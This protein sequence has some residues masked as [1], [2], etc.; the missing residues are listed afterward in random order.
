VL[1]CWG[2]DDVKELRYA[3]DASDGP[4]NAEMVRRG[5]KNHVISTQRLATEGNTAAIS[6]PGG[7][8]TIPAIDNMIHYSGAG[9]LQFQIPTRSQANAGF[10]QDNFNKVLG[11]PSLYLGPNSPNGN[12]FY[13]Q[14]K[15]RL[16]DVMLNTTIRELAGSYFGLLSTSG[17]GSDILITD[18][19][20]RFE[21]SFAGREIYILYSQNNFVAG[22]YRITQFIDATHIKLDRSPTPNGAGKSGFGAV[23]GDPDTGRWNGV[24]STPGRGSN[25]VVHSG[26]PYD[27]FTKG[28]VG[29]VFQIRFNGNNFV[30]GNY[31][32]TEFIDATHLRLNQSPTPAGAGTQ[33]WGVTGRIAG[34]W[35]VGL[36]TG[37]A[38]HGFFSYETVMNNGYQLGY[39]QIYGNLGVEGAPV[40]RSV[41]YRAN[42]WQ[43]ITI[44]EEVRGPAR[45]TP[46][47]R[48][49]WWVDGVLA[50]NW[51]THTIFWGDDGHGGQTGPGQFQML[52]YHT[53]KDLTQDHDTGYMWLDDLI[54]STQPIPMTK[55]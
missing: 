10:F 40:Q 41:T 6:Q 9:S 16:N 25:V 38:P 29:K 31:T 44:R 53:N 1:G 37:N 47:S 45:F 14:F 42:Q 28:M 48:V 20:L 15:L 5:L 32:V 19:A 24:L 11:N 8:L 2:F 46:V 54:V 3:W 39:P 26:S 55:Q 4:L 21:P 33:G 36:L 12:V 50:G 7:A 13:T 22:Y 27:S 49:T 34:G 35:K 51:E 52:P 17:A 18:P 23:G 43:E 30:A